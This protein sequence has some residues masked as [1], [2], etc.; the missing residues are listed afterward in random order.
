MLA[1]TVKDLKAKDLASRK[2]R[3]VWIA[4]HWPP[5]YSDL[6][7]HHR[8]ELGFPT[9]I[10]G[11]SIC[12]TC[13][14]LMHVTPCVKVVVISELAHTHTTCNTQRPIAGNIAAAVRSNECGARVLVWQNL[15]MGCQPEALHCQV[16]GHQPG[17]DT[18][19]R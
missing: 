16:C 4:L 3:L 17:A 10:E 15:W 8:K 2:R 18:V 6:M 7:V 5:L 19:R 14:C 1:D 11:P 13:P 12:T 9:G